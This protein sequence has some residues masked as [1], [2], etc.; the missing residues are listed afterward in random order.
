M[1]PREK[2]TCQ[3]CKKQIHNRLHARLECE[4]TGGLNTDAHNKA[5]CH[6][7]AALSAS[8]RFEGWS[9][10][11]NA[12]V[13]NGYTHDHTVPAELLP[14]RPN[15]RNGLHDEP[16]ILLYKG[17]DGPGHPLPA[18]KSQVQLCFVEF[19]YRTDGTILKRRN[20]AREIYKPLFLL[21][22]AEGYT[23]IG[24]GSGPILAGNDMD[25]DGE[26][27]DGI[28]PNIFSLI[29]GASDVYTRHFMDTLADLGVRTGNLKLL[30]KKLHSTT[31]RAL[32]STTAVHRRLCKASKG[33]G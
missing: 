20:E 6:I 33:V 3:L 28:P 2:K 11:V 1:V 30:L 16:D 31:L 12:G 18:D 14:G 19:K 8:P 32:H 7:A 10:L 26:G 29:L 23:I 13:K 27:D 9:M 15:T 22:K 24:E 5:A 4:Q 17:W 21:L 25:I